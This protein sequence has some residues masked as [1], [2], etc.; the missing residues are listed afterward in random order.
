MCLI[1]ILANASQSLRHDSVSQKLNTR[2]ARDLGM[3]KE[4]VVVGIE[5]VPPRGP[6]VT[7]SLLDNDALRSAVPISS[8]RFWIC[9]YATDSSRIHDYQD[10]SLPEY[11]RSGFSVGDRVLLEVSNLEPDIQSEPSVSGTNGDKARS[12]STP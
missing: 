6:Y 7:L 10:E 4:L 2:D 5:S 9:L 12:G 8:C 1:R 3:K 11:R